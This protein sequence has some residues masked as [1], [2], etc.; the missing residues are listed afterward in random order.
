MIAA[1]VLFSLWDGRQTTYWAT[2]LMCLFQMFLTT[3]LN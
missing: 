3:F 2:L 1:M